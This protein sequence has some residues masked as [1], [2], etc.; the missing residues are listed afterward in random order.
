MIERE[1]LLALAERLDAWA[2][3]VSSGQ[4]AALA[5]RDAAKTLRSAANT[6]AESHIK[7]CFIKTKGE[8]LFTVPGGTVLVTL[9][10]YAIVPIEDWEAAIAAL[11][12]PAGESVTLEELAK[13][14]WANDHEQIGPG[15]DERAIAHALLSIFTITRKSEA[16]S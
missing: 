11:P 3:P 14:I 8:R 5:M 6:R 15:C 16:R 1:E 10:G 7:N 9:D 4:D 13:F 2:G 12:A